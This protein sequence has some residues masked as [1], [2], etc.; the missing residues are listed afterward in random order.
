MTVALSS[1][2]LVAVRSQNRWRKY[3]LLV[4]QPAVV[5]TA[6]VNGTYTSFDSIASIPFDGGLGSLAAI[7][8]GMTCYIGSYAG[9]YDRGIVR[10]RAAIIGSEILI[11]V[12]SDVRPLD[13]DYI[14]VVE[15]FMPDSKISASVGGVTTI[16][17][18]VQFSVT[19][20]FAPLVRSGSPAV[21]L[22]LT[23]AT[24]AHTPSITI[25]SPTGETAASYQHY[26][27]GSSA[28]S[29]M[30]TASPTI[31]YNATGEYYERYTVTDSA[32]AVGFRYAKIIV[33]SMATS[34]FSEVSINN[35]TGDVDSSGWSF[36]LTG[37]SGVSLATMRDRSL[38]V[39]YSEDY[40]NSAAATGQGFYPDAVNVRCIGWLDAETLTIASDRGFSSASFTVMGAGGWM[41]KISGSPMSLADVSIAP[42][43]WN[44]IQSMTVDMALYRL[45]K[46]Q[47]TLADICD[48]TFT[49]DT[50]RIQFA[51]ANTGSQLAQVNSLAGLKLIASIV[52]DRLSCGFVFKSPSVMTA[53][54]R[55]AV[56]VLYSINSEDWQSIDVD[57]KTSASSSMIEVNGSSWDGAVSTLIYARAPGN[58]SNPH[59]VPQSPYTELA[60][61]ASSDCA[62]IAGDVYASDN[63]PYPS[64]DT[65][66]FTNND[67]LDIAPAQVVIISIV[68]GDNPRGMA[69]SN[70][71]AIPQSITVGLSDSD[72]MSV[73]W[74]L[75]T[76]GN[77]GVIYTP[78]VITSG[79][80]D[81]IMPG[82][83]NKKG[84]KLVP[85][86]KP[87][88]PPSITPAPIT[89]ACVDVK[90]TFFVAWDAW[91]LEADDKL[92]ALSHFPCKIRPSSMTNTTYMTIQ[93][94]YCANSHV[95]MVIAKG[96]THIDA[97]DRDG[98]VM[99]TG[100]VST[101]PNN[102]WGK[103]TVTFSTPSELDIDGFK[104]SIDNVNFPPEDILSL[105]EFKHD[106]F[107]YSFYGTSSLLASTHVYD[108]YGILSVSDVMTGT[109]HWTG[110]RWRDE[111]ELSYP[112]IRRIYIDVNAIGVS[113]AGS[114]FEISFAGNPAFLSVAVPPSFSDVIDLGDV[115]SGFFEKV[116][117][118][119]DWAT[120][121]SN[122]VS[123]WGRYNFL[124]SQSSSV[125][126]IFISYGMGI[127][128]NVCGIG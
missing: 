42:K 78:E 101:D 75:E 112:G 8:P 15:D 37:Y 36:A 56:P 99:L 35:F 17:T 12:T 55:S 67:F 40:I 98:N 59:G 125:K 65:D 109:G 104:I 30:T 9:A 83:G 81:L 60:L 1:P 95:G 20:S 103:T 66:L 64:I 49:G 70:A 23:G 26:A 110:A 43:N 69:I 53:A 13:N 94:V 106:F 32:G 31:T 90:N 102:I 57:R 61:S 86:S 28:S 6:R 46:W 34:V 127:I 33:I 10:V 77:D 25:W 58:T 87:K 123:W 97:V 91:K 11:G 85:D 63:N 5:Y 118:T 3:F 120:T 47:S 45:I 44:Q 71:R 19:K 76:D 4:S 117:L 119:L 113:A 24:V 84:P 74:S 121:D 108:E 88:F 92:S 21:V 115:N 22:K 62:R 52:F 114:L 96:H 79:I 116:K 124:T 73:N 48:F 105:S 51:V 82:F 41:A 54:E 126:P 80:D 18:D 89:G 16:D 107:K 122:P 93:I 100:A 111:I 7:M 68:A 39:L 2:Q 14:T 72:Q 38:C 128:N 50:T 29:G 27:T